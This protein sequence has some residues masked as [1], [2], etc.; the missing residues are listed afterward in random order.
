[1]KPC[2]KLVGED[3]H[4]FSII[5]R[6]SKALRKQCD[7]GTDK[8]FIDKATNASSYDEVLQIVQDYVE[9]Y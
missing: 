8:E 4:V 6:V 1:M 3:G 2:V 5:A 7:D 9:V